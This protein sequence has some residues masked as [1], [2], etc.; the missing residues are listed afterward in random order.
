VTVGPA[1][2]RIFI[3]HL[4]AAITTSFNFISFEGKHR[5]IRSFVGYEFTGHQ[6]IIGKL[7]GRGDRKP[8]VSTG[9]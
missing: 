6:I 9:G 5:E 4:A 1:R 8:P 7:G 3:E 2:L